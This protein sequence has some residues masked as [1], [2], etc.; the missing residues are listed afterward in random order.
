SSV[1]VS[2]QIGKSE[3]EKVITETLVSQ[4]PKYVETL[5]T[6]RSVA[7]EVVDVTIPPS[8][9]V[10]DQMD[11][12]KKVSTGPVIESVKEKTITPDAAQDVGASTAQTN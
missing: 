10:N 5:D 7:K 4:N 12:S 9:A 11:V 6:S 2:E 8:A 3:V 1:K